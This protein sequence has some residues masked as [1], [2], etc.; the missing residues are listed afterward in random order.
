MSDWNQDSRKRNI[1][2]KML[3]VIYNEL[4]FREFLVDVGNIDVVEQNQNGKRSQKNFEVDFIARKGSKNYCIQSALS[5]Y[6]EGKAATELRPLKA[7]DDSFKKIIISKSYGKSWTD[8]N[9]ILR[10]GIM[11]FLLAENSLDR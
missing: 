6:D 2:L 1:L 5:M 9:G 11:D 8:E 7:I 4:R 3:Y 10:L